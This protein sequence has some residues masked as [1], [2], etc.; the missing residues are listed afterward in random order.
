VSR[1]LGARVADVRRLLEAA[2][3]VYDEKGA[4]VA[5]LAR[6]TGL[7][8]EGV[9]LG[10]ESLE[11]E[12]SD[13]ELEALVASAGDAAH[14]HVIL[15]ANVFIAPLRA[16]ALARAASV[17]VT[18]RPS[19]RDPVLATALVAAAGDPAVTIVP[20][21]DDHAEIPAAADRVDVYGR[22]ETIATVRAAVRTGVAV[23][24]HGAGL[25]VA[26]VTEGESIEAAAR[27][28]ACD[29]VPFD[30]RGC[31][32]PRIVFVEGTAERGAAFAG[33]LDECLSLA[34]S[35]VP[36]GRLTEAEQAD[37]TRW[38]DALTFVGRVWGGGDHVV[39]F[40]AFA[41]N[42]PLAVPPPGRHVLVVA[43]PDPGEIQAALAP[44]AR[45]VVTVGASDL[46][47]L[48]SSLAASVVPAH[49][50]LARLGA[51]QR[52]P[53]DGPVDRRVSL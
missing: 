50:R 29:V 28:L 53:L 41:G 30:Q 2:R 34:A 39:A 1:A 8:Q 17:R 18:V 24:G 6:A 25:G 43:A 12:A 45:F 47:R 35:R 27:A 26:V 44:M 15:S 9:A 21:H 19:S 40:A 4:L 48:A 22:D 20:S 33:S 7:S 46:A 14:V 13:A 11:R 16:I 42:V 37:A 38:R 10:F 49:A 3:R 32:S 23:R 36:R 31:L 52:P 51:M 5:D